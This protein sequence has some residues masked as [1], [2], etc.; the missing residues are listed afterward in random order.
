MNKQ[1]MQKRI[2]RIEGKCNRILSELVIIRERLN[3]ERDIDAIIDRLHQ[4][5][6]RIR[7]QCERERDAAIRIA[8]H[9][10]PE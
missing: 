3:R 4:T 5:A 9:Q 7:R 6:K 1:R 10:K 8:N 2:I